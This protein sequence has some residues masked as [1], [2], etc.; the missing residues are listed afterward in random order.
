MIL[1]LLLQ[2]ADKRT[3]DNLV[4]RTKFDQSIGSLD[5][6]L[7]ELLHR[8]EGQVCNSYVEVFIAKNGCILTFCNKYGCWLKHG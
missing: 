7:Q 3:L 6:S 5:Q 2:K 1:F 4:N 8:L